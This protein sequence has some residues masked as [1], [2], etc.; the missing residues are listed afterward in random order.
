MQNELPIP[1]TAGDP[2]ICQQ[3]HCPLRTEG[4]DADQLADVIVALL[5]GD[6][7]PPVMETGT[8]SRND[9][10]RECVQSI[11]EGRRLPLTAA[12]AE[13]KARR[14]SLRLVRRVHRARRRS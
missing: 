5:T 9:L 11:F 12:E 14:A 3:P 1:G 10:C 6:D 2:T 4:V 7:L 8:I 13:E